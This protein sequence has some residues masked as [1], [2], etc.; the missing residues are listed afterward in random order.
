VKRST[1]RAWNS[2]RHSHHPKKTFAGL[3]RCHGLAPATNAVGYR[4]LYNEACE[5]L[6]HA[7]GMFSLP[8]LSVLAELDLKQRE[9]RDAGIGRE[10]G[11][12]SGFVDWPSVPPDG[13]L[14]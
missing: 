2:L 3:V 14:W 9:L 4:P 1:P 10:L 13:I 8:K 5:Y 7:A 6:D 12:A 11:F